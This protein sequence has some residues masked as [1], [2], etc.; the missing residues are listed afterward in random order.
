M[1]PRQ[2]SVSQNSF[3]SKSF[4]ALSFA[5]YMTPAFFYTRLFVD[6]GI[7]YKNVNEKNLTDCQ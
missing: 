1:E 7:S 6:V 3:P 2:A 5:F 4:Q